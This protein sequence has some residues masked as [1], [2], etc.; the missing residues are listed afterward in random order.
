MTSMSVMLFAV[1][2]AIARRGLP[3][4]KAVDVSGQFGLSVVSHTVADQDRWA[5]ALRFDHPKMG[6]PPRVYTDKDG[7][8]REHRTLFGT[9]HGAEVLLRYSADLPADDAAGVAA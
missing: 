2:E 3:E 4:P 9:W 1:A 6:T 7:V 8:R 5:K